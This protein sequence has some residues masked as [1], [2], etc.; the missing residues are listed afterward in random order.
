MSYY[1]DLAFHL[2]RRKC[3]EQQVLDVLRTAEKAA[4]GGDPREACGDAEDDAAQHEG[5][6]RASP[7]QRALAPFGVAGLLCVLLHAIWPGWFSIDVPVLRQLTGMI[8]LLLLLA[9]GS[10][11]AAAVD[12]RLPRGF[13]ASTASR[14]G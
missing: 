5:P 11:V 3:T 9:I 13:A 14:S 4:E 8:A 2:R 1:H 6:R 7:G 10:I 12:H